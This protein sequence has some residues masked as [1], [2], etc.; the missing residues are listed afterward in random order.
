MLLSFQRAHPDRS[1]V[2]LIPRGV[3]QQEMWQQILR[4]FAGGG[5]N[6][7]LPDESRSRETTWGIVWGDVPR[8]LHPH[9][10][11]F[12]HLTAFGQ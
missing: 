8:G 4:K 5:T 1:H 11:F 10:H 3:N 7:K 6:S 12:D 2:R 9:A